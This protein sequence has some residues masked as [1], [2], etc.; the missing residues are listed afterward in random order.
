VFAVVSNAPG[1]ADRI[2]GL[3]AMSS[4]AVVFVV[5]E[6]DART[7]APGSAAP[8]SAAPVSAELRSSGWTVVDCSPDESLP[9][10]WRSLG[11]ARGLA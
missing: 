4:H 10:L 2:R 5:G 7:S 6:T 9:A 1:A 8:V 11:E 3:A